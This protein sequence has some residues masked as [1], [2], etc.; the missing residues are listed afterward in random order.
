MSDVVVGLDVHLKKTQVTIMKMNGEIVKREKVDTS[1]D[2]LKGSLRCV[3][4]G[5]KVALESVGFCWPW[6]D[7]LDELGFEPLLANPVKVKCRAEDVKTDRVDSKLLADL[8]RMNWLPTCYVPP[9]ELRWLRNLLRHRAFRT[10]LSTGVKNRTRSEFRKRDIGLMVNLGT[11][12]GRKAAFALDVFEVS[13]NMELLDLMEKQTKEVEMMLRRKYGQ[14]KPVQLLMTI[15][16]IGFLSAVT[17]YAEICDIKRFSNSEKLAHYAGLV[18][19]VRQSGDHAWLGRETKGDAWLKWILIEASW[20]H[21]RF[22]PEGRLAG[23]F[24]DA[25]KRKG[26]SKD[27]IKVVARKLVNVVWAVLTY[28]KEFMVK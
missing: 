14:V 3:P 11:L 5:S 27:A 23:V 20:A 19:R 8:T 25:C 15:P 21:V 16:G 12:K 6:I 2:S 10:R 28:E 17:L 7:F 18:P 9:S 24:E 4:K 22:C 13:Q 1:K 26:N